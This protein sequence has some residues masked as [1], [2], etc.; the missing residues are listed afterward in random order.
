LVCSF[1]Y[2]GA[3]KLSRELL[4]AWLASSL[5]ENPQCRLVMVGGHQ[6]QGGYRDE[7]EA[8]VGRAQSAGVELTGYVDAQTYRQY[9]AAADVAV[10]LRADSRG[11]TSR[12]V[13]DAMAHGVML[14][15]NAHGSAAELP[16]DAVMMLA[17]DCTVEQIS[18][19]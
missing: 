1:G 6:M 12:A 8:E 17:D 7:L 16:A 2:V 18:E 13:L 3:G 14:I 4:Q 9:L 19:A 5:A 10:Q 11:E 15:V